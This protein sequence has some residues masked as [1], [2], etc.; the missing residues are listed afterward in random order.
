MITG[1][2]G[3]IGRHLLED[4]DPRTVDMTVITR[5]PSRQFPYLPAGT[6]VVRADLADADSL[7]RAF[8]G[9]D[10]ILNIAAELRRPE[11][12]VETNVEGTKNIIRAMK[13]NG[14]K[15]IIHLSSVGV[16]GAQYSHSPQSVS[17][18]TPVSPKNEY[19]RTKL[20]SEELLKKAAADGAFDLAVLRPTNVFGE[21]HPYH[22]LLNFI[23]R[24]GNEK[25]MM[26]TPGA[27]VNY[28][29]VKDLTGAMIRLIDNI[30]K[31]GVFNTGDAVS[32]KEFA[33][34]IA[35]ELNVRGKAYTIPLFLVKFMEMLGVKKLRP[36]SNAITYDDRRLK[37]FYDYPYGVK[38]GL[39]RTIAHYKKQ[40]LL[41]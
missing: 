7:V 36:V 1:A 35:D 16:V 5:D 17:E 28:V 22:A 38:K 3:F 13:E 11:K 25:V 31:N 8:S 40:H 15:R 14:V 10:L 24:T 33:A 39:Q 23:S 41:K 30:D 27:M 9:A 37:E 21:H 34:F 4:I 2:G 29:Y 18:E 19:E 32:L 12:M 26:H 6:K 20:L